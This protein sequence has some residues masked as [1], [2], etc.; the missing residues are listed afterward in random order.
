MNDPDSYDHAETKYWDM[1]DHIVVLTTFRGKN[2]FGG[3][4][5]NSVKAKISLDGESI[6]IIEQY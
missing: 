3:T 1:D 5:K 2:A 4:V 6:E